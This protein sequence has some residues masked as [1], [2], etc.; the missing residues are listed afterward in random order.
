MTTNPPKHLISILRTLTERERL[1]ILAELE[2]IIEKTDED[3]TNY[4]DKDAD[5]D[6]NIWRSNIEETS[7]RLNDAQR[8]YKAVVKED[9]A[10]RYIWKF[11]DARMLAKAVKPN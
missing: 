10:S 11:V 4:K 8:A 6:S 1:V 9:Y 5:A 2:G 7:D 3:L